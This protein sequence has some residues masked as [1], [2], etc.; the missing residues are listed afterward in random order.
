MK[1]EPILL[2]TSHITKKY[3][4]AVTALKVSEI[5]AV[6][7]SREDRSIPVPCKKHKIS[8]SV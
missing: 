1:D 4:E 3:S 5:K 7:C 8:E 6:F 2:E